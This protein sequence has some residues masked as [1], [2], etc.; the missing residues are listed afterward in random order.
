MIKEVQIELQTR[1]L[2]IS[3]SVLI[4]THGREELLTKCLD[5]MSWGEQ[6]WQ[7]V[8]VANGQRLTSALVERAQQLTPHFSLLDLPTQVKPGV[9]R[10]L[11]LQACQGEWIFFL[12]D[13]AFL[14]PTYSAL[15]LP[16]LADAR[17]EVLGGPDAPAPQMSSFS[18]GLGLTLTSPLCT[19]ITHARH[20]P[21]GK[22]LRPA[23][24]NWLTSCNLWIR[25]K[26]L[27]ELRF[28]EEY[29]RTEETMLLTQLRQRG[30]SMWY[31]PR[32]SVFHFRRQ[33]LAQLWR[34]T[35]YAGYYRARLQRQGSGSQQKYFWLPAVFV[36]LHFVIFIDSASFWSMAR[37][38]LGVVGIFSLN[39]CLRAGRT[40]LFAWVTFFHYFI[41]LV[42]G[43][44]FLAEKAGV[45]IADKS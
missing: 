4:I 8:M 20:H 3:F 34:P 18:Y 13:D 1:A 6:S 37:I 32:L 9:A 41:V 27:H 12:D 44:G 24:E 25:R 5:S 22:G 2:V 15:L 40:G 26:L 30:A 17:I 19:G 31:H 42:Y 7:L 28:P 43:L 36:L 10:N 23:D 14:P 16:L 29:L 39:L 45:Q 38:Y 33:N 11:A 21:V 35:L